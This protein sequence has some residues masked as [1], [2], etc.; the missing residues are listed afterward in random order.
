MKKPDWR[1]EADYAHVTIETIGADGVAWEF[2]RRNQHYQDDYE[3]LK[4][5]TVKDT[6]GNPPLTVNDDKYAGLKEGFFVPPL[7]PDQG[8]R[9]WLLEEPGRRILSPAD[10]LAAK[11]KVGK[12]VDPQK[13]APEK[14]PVF[15]VPR[16]PRIITQFDELDELEAAGD[17]SEDQEDSGPTL[18]SPNNILVAFSLNETITPQWNRIK[19]R[20]ASLQEKHANFSGLKGTSSPKLKAWIPALRAWDSQISAADMP[21]VERAVILYSNDDKHHVSKSFDDHYKTA[22]RLIEGEYLDIARRGS[23]YS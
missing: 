20:L 14:L 11:W 15:D 2:L 8:H 23:G 3:A 17:P 5:G 22:K 6:E 10:Y 9:A 7:K 1:I 12:L 21:K 16:H 18:L 4:N 19:K 13:N